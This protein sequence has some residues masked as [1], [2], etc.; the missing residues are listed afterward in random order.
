VRDKYAATPKGTIEL[1]RFFLTGVKTTGGETLTQEAVLERLKAV[2]AVE[3]PAAPLSD[4]KIAAALKAAGCPV[5]RRTIA[6]YRDR[7]GIP[8]ASRRRLTTDRG[9]DTGESASRA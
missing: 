5:A 9:G 2:V 1:R 7:L 6:K 8:G 3:D 4:E